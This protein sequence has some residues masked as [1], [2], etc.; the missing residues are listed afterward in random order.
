MT[1]IPY[2]LKKSSL[3]GAVVLWGALG[4]FPNAASAS[5]RYTVPPPET[6]ARAVVCQNIKALRAPYYLQLSSTMIHENNAIGTTVGIFSTDPEAGVCTYALVK[7]ENSTDNDLFTIAGNTLKALTILDYET[8]TDRYVRVRCTDTKGEYI[9]K[10]FLIEVLDV[11]EVNNTLVATNLVTP[12][13]D[14][15]NDTWVVQ[16]LP[17]NSMN[18]VRIMDRSGRVVYY[19]RNYTNEWNGQLTNGNLL[20]EG[21][22]YYII[23]FGA[24]LHPFKGSI[25]LIR[26]RK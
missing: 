21:V 7:G 18:E 25:T 5:S 4:L 3:C 15:K 24:G 6:Q 19:K 17:P 12:N 23:D 10:A 1:A 22:Y 26:S 13:G 2:T 20:A 9:E 11:F 14:G 8:Q 16:N